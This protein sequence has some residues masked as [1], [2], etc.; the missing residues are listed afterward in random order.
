MKGSKMK[1]KV[2]VV[3]GA[4]SG[5]GATIFYHLLGT[6]NIPIGIDVK[7]FEVSELSR[8]PCM[9]STDC[10]FYQGD[11]S[12]VADM[13]TI[14]K[15]IKKVDGLVNNAGLLGTDNLHGGRSLESF[16][17]MMRAH[18]HTALVLTELCYPLMPQGGS[19]VNI[20]SIDTHMIMPEAVLYAAAKG[21]LWGLTLGYSITL[22]PKGIRVN[23]VSPGSVQTERD[24]LQYTDA[25]G[26]SIVAG[27]IAKTP[28]KR[29]VE[30]VEVAEL[31]S[32]LLSDK[33]SA[34][35]GQETVIDCGY[36]RAL[37]DPCWTEKNPS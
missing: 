4:A 8:M 3:S 37:Y 29:T 6:G 18:T 36:T 34:I 21:A 13:A 14:F 1:N 17:K 32:F 23:M 19:I 7:H 16:T 30:P 5:I 25:R 9:A 28:L 22:A 11:A 26:K 12:S 2:I 27:F 15:N 31:V 24:K 20:G 33:A 10:E 35:T